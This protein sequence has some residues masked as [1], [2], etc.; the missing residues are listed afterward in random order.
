VGP[1]A[2]LDAVNGRLFSNED[3]YE[4]RKVES[5][6]RLFNNAISKADYEASNELRINVNNEMRRMS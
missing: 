2:V 5:C 3:D 4:R 6:H 1:R